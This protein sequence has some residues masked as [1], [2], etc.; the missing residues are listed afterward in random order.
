M[1]EDCNHDTY[2][3]ENHKYPIVEKFSIINGDFSCYVLDSNTV[4]VP[5]QP[6]FG[7]CLERVFFIHFIN[8]AISARDI[9]IP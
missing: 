9:R 6:D 5:E 7:K 4:A 3:L 1:P 2:S 8:N